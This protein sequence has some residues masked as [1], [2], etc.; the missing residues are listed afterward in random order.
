MKIIVKSEIVDGVITTVESRKG[1]TSFWIEKIFYED[2]SYEYVT[3]NKTTFNYH[4]SKS[5]LVMLEM[6]KDIKD[7]LN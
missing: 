6:G 5:T 4:S 3:R 2:G 7:K 1:I